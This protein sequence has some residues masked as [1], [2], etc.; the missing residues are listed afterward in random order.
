MQITGAVLEELGRPGPWSRTRPLTV[1][2]LELDPPGPGEVLVEI[3]AADSS[4]LLGRRR[5]PRPAGPDA[6]GPRGERARDDARSGSQ[7]PRRRPAGGDDVPAALRRVRRLRAPVAGCRA[8]PGRPATPRASC[9][10]AVAASAVTAYR[11]TTT[12]GCRPS[13]RTPSSTPARS[14]R[15][16]TTCRR[17]SP[18]CSAAR[19]SP[20]VARCS[21]PAV[22]QPGQSVMVV[23]LGGVGMAALLTAVAIGLVKVVA[24]DGVAAKR[25]RALELVARTRGA[26]P[27]RA[28]RRATRGA[29][30]SSRPRA[31]P[32]RS[33]RPSR[34]PHP[35]D[36]P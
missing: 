25:E 10:A 32:G 23:G 29:T 1:G 34:Q 4:Y 19:C 15:S 24:V 30:S 18:R 3:A 20:G 35:A 5:Q 11:C 22:P 17:T 28:G 8:A 27:G 6:A 31:V 7:R 26:R 36:A 12:S 16:R 13:P 14:S 9:S 33:S 21:M 2:T